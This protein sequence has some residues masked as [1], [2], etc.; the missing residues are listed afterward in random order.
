MSKLSK[1]VLLKWNGLQ[2]FNAGNFGNLI[3]ILEVGGGTASIS[4]F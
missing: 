2:H 4:S 1:N 3:K